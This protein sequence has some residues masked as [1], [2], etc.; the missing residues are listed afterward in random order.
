[1]SV[2]VPQGSVLGALIYILFVNELPTVVNDEESNQTSMPQDQTKQEMLCC[3]VDDST[4]TVSSN[5]PL[6]LT[7]KLSSLYKRLAS[8][9]G[10]NKLVINTEKTHLVVIGSN[11][12]SLLRQQVTIDTGSVIIKPVET[13]KLLGLN[14]HQ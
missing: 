13:E 3:Y 6:E 10:S 9:F 4:V 5:D 1:M 14:I 12:H 7:T 2:G 11:K 8:F